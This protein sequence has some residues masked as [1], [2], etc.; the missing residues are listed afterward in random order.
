[1][2]S[3]TSEYALRVV[4]YLGSLDGTPATTKDLA[5][6]TKIPE[7]YLAKVIRSLNRAGLVLS[8]RGLHGG[9]ILARSPEDITMFDVVNAV[10]PIQR[11]RT[12]PL[13]IR[14]HGNVLC[15]VHKRLDNAI[16]LVERAFKQSTIA[17]MLSEPS[18]SRPLCDVS[19]D[20]K[21]K[22]KGRLTPLTFS[23]A[24]KR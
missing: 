22:G 12:C 4:A 21:A 7:G 23:A 8:Q 14:S 9:S 6:A 3:Q 1:M 20:L 10:A 11:I 5:V 19:D 18:S 13:G 16:A 24:R 15:P 17:D 2:F